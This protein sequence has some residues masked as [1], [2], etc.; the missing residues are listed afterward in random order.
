[1]NIERRLGAVVLAGSLA[2]LAASP[3]AQSSA[4]APAR[5]SAAIPQEPFRSGVEIVSLN[6]TVADAVGRYATDLGQPDFQVFEDGVKQDVTL[7]NR[8]NSPIALSLL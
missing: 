3:T 7:F 5:Q 2:C 6:V 8:T 4:P 1:M